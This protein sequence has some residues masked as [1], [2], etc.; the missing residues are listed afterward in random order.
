MGLPGVD[1]VEGIV[2]VGEVDAPLLVGKCVAASSV[3]EPSYC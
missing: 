2:V 1:N 3:V